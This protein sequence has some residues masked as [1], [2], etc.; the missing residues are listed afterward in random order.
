MTKMLMMLERGRLIAAGAGVGISHD[1][2]KSD[3]E[4]RRRNESVDRKRN[5]GMDVD[6][7]GGGDRT[8]HLRRKRRR[9]GRSDQVVGSRRRLLTRY[10]VRRVINEGSGRL[11]VIRGQRDVT[12]GIFFAEIV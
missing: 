9:W 12:H 5:A 6:A 8:Q 11:G 2:A 4:G 1:F 3:A 7:R 10:Y